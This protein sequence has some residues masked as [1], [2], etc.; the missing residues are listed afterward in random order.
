MSEPAGALANGPESRYVVVALDALLAGD[1]D[2]ARQALDDGARAT[3]WAAV[4]HRL[5]VAGRALAGDE[6]LPGSPRPTVVDTDPESVAAVFDAW[7]NGTGL[8]VTVDLT[9]GDVAP[10]APEE[11]A[12]LGLVVLGSLL[13]RSGFPPQVVV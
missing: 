9:T 10:A 13:D 4:T 6:E 8:S 3:S 1:E 5:D 2:R 11:Q 7:L 12:W